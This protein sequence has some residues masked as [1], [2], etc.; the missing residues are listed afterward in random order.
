MGGRP[1]RPTTRSPPLRHGRIFPEAAHLRSHAPRGLGEHSQDRVKGHSSSPGPGP[2]HGLGNSACPAK[3]APAGLAGWVLQLWPPGQTCGSAVAHA[4]PQSGEEGRR[5]GAK[6]LPVPSRAPECHLSTRA[7]SGFSPASRWPPAGRGGGCISHVPGPP[8]PKPQPH[9]W[10][11]CTPTK[12]HV[13]TWAG[14]PPA[15]LGRGEAG[16]CVPAGDEFVQQ[17]SSVNRVTRGPFTQLRR[18]THSSPSEA[19]NGQP[20]RDKSSHPLAPLPGARPVCG[21]L[22]PDRGGHRPATSWVRTLTTSLGFSLTGR[23]WERLPPRVPGPEQPEQAG[24]G[25]PP[26]G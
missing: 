25:A 22:R 19:H 4:G 5:L 3:G 17:I 14:L 9:S 10:V 23:Q 7:A 26:W 24:P 18:T 1:P 15:S 2:L 8:P 13:T 6:L 16:L 12:M 21:S 11:R 20:A